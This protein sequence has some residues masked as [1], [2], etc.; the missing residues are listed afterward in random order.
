MDANR[1]LL[2]NGFQLGYAEWGDKQGTPIFFFGGS[3]SS[4]IMRHPDD[5]ILTALG[6]H[7]YTF[8]RP[9]FGLS[10]SQ[11]QRTLL[12]WAND[13]RDFA[14]QKGIPRF[15]VV[16]ASQG[17]PYG[18]VCAYA[19][20]DVLSSVS[21]VSA[22]SP[23]HDP[24]VFA[25]QT[26]AIK[27]MLRMARHAPWLMTLQNNLMRFL[28]KGNLAK[29]LVHS[30]LGN[31]PASD[32]QHLNTPESIELLI[33]DMREAT[34]QSGKSVTLDMQVVLRDWGFR[35]ED[36]QTRVFLWQGEDD[37]NV[38]PEMARYM[39]A[40]I[41]NCEATFVPNAGHFLAFSHWREIMT[42][43]LAAF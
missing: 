20:P 37:P 1:V 40:R 25:S 4:R 18:A 12:D 7:L 15:A 9:G 24:A 35:L 8:D 16:A 26:P 11:P 29:K 28:L 39:A 2:K 6:I 34:R 41:P 5:S 27:T 13:I 17:G 38:T 33:A 3:S 22:V 43:A 14:A 32:Q 31:L 21:L 42:Q 36:I 30:L 19:L 23:L 10:D